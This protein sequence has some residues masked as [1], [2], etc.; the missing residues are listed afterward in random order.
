MRFF[1]PLA[2]AA[3]AESTLSRRCTQLW[4]SADAAIDNQHFILDT[5]PLVNKVI[6]AGSLHFSIELAVSRHVTL[7][8]YNWPNNVHWRFAHASNQTP[9]VGRS[10]ATKSDRKDMLIYRPDDEMS[11]SSCK[12]ILHRATVT[13]P[14]L[15]GLSVGNMLIRMLTGLLLPADRVRP[16]VIGYLQ[17]YYTSRRI[18]LWAL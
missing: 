3:D 8:I 6:C 10:P 12:F 11:I 16:Q 1:R 18:A 7:L 4:I 17:Y 2:A 14:I 9:L 5:G 13:V 15:M